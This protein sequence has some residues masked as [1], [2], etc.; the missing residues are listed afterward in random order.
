MEQAR[1]EFW[2]IP[3]R[4]PPKYAKI[5]LVLAALMLPIAA[6][7]LTLYDGWYRISYVSAFVLIGL[8]NALWAVGCLVPD[9]PLS[10]ALRSAMRPVVLLMFVALA[11]TL[12]FQ[13]G[14]WG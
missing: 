5:V 6:L 7:G 3:G 13:F 9:G 2:R 1:Q 10:L 11:A 14:L 4:I 12:G 8:G